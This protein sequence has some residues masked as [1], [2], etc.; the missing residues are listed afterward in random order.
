MIEQRVVATIPV[1]D[2]HGAGEGR[3]RGR[4]GAGEGRALTRVQTRPVRAGRRPRDTR[5]G[6]R[7]DRAPYVGAR[8]S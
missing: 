6:N 5:T 3:V 7:G 4:R 2:G 8:Y 1:V